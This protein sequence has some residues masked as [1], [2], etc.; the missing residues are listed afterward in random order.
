MSEHI[1]APRDGH[2]LTQ[3]LRWDGPGWYGSV[4]SQ[5]ATHIWRYAGEW[6]ED[7]YSIDPEAEVQRVQDARE[8]LG[9]PFYLSVTDFDNDEFVK[10]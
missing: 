6:D 7:G 2:G 9:T 5:D 1:F 4:G 10:I 8:N 3:V